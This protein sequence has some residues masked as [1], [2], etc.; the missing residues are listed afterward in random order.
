MTRVGLVLGGGG[1]TGTAFHAGVISALGSLG[2]DARGASV[3]IGTSAGSTT[4][5]VLRAGLPPPDFLRRMLGKPLSDQGKSILGR[6]DQLQMP[7]TLPQWRARPAAPRLL[8]AALRH[9]RRYTTGTLIAA[10]LPSGTIPISS[11]A[12]PVGPAFDEWPA[13]PLWVTALSLTTGERAVFGRD[14]CTTLTAA[15]SASC[16]IP[17][18]FSPVDIDG[19]RFVDGGNYSTHHLDLLTSDDIDLAVVSAPMG[20]A[21]P[22][23]LDAGNVARRPIRRQLDREIARVRNRGVQVLVITPDR[24]VRDVM[25]VTTMQDHK[26][27]HVALSAYHYTRRVVSAVA[28]RGG[29]V[30]PGIRVFDQSSMG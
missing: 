2:W 17:G 7:R 29:A 5:A 10:A 6:I 14:R 13:D 19:E 25:G 8:S 24:G 15:V 16:A 30:P 4:G 21:N 28:G 18:Y 20:T 11:V 23:E 26:R 1:L 9:P 22:R 27:P 3:V 12:P